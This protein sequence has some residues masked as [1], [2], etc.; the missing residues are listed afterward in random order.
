MANPT[1][2]L[3]RPWIDLSDFGLRVLHTKDAKNRH[4][5]MLMPLSWEEEPEQS[6]ARLNELQGRLSALVG[7][8]QAPVAGRLF[9]QDR[10]WALTGSGLSTFRGIW[11][12]LQ[13]GFPE[14]RLNQDTPIHYISLPRFLQHYAAQNAEKPSIKQDAPATSTT[15]TPKAVVELNDQEKKLAEFIAQ[16]TDV[17][18]RLAA[19]GMVTDARLH[20][21]LDQ[22]EEVI[23]EIKADE[24]NAFQGIL[25][26]Q[27]EDTLSVI[28]ANLEARGEG[29][30]ENMGP[31]DGVKLS[32]VIEAIQL[33]GQRVGS[34]NETRGNVQEKGTERTGLTE[35]ETIRSAFEKLADYELNSWRGLSV[36][37]EG[38]ETHYLACQR[39]SNP[40]TGEAPV[41]ELAALDQGGWEIPG[42]KRGPKWLYH[43]ALEADN[44]LRQI[45][46]F[47]AEPSM[48]EMW[49]QQGLPMPAFNDAGDAGDTGAAPVN[50][51][52]PTDM[53]TVATAGRKAQRVTNS[54]SKR[55]TFHLNEALRQVGLR[56][57]GAQENGGAD[58]E[59]LPALLEEQAQIQWKLF[60]IEAGQLMARIESDWDGMYKD[61]RDRASAL[62][63]NYPEL[64]EAMR[65]VSLE[66][67]LAAAHNL[68]VRHRTTAV[69]D[70][71]A[72]RLLTKDLLSLAEKT[73][74]NHERTV[75]FL[76]T[77][78]TRLNI[79]DDLDF[80][81]L[82]RAFAQLK[83]A[84]G[85]SV[86]TPEIEP[87]VRGKLEADIT[88][89][90][91]E[92]ENG[93]TDAT[94]SLTTGTDGSDRA[95]LQPGSGQPSLDGSRHAD[96]AGSKSAGE[97]DDR[98]GDQSSPAEDAG[99]AGGVR[100]SD[101]SGERSPG[102]S[103]ISGNTSDAGRQG[104]TEAADPDD[105]ASVLQGGSGSV[106]NGHAGGDAGR[107]SQASAGADRAPDSASQDPVSGAEGQT[108]QAGSGLRA[109]VRA[110]ADAGPGASGETATERQSDAGDSASLRSSDGSDGASDERSPGASGLGQ[111]P[112][113]D[114]FTYPEGHDLGGKTRA[115]R[116]EDNLAAMTLLF[117]LEKEEREPTNEERA[118]L[119]EYS[120]WGGID[121]NLFGYGNK[122]NFAIEAKAAI[123]KFRNQDKLS[124]KEYNSLQSTV[125]NAHYTHSGII[126]PMWR[127]IERLGV[128]VG[129]ILEP[130]CGL[131]NFKAY[132]PEPLATKSRFTGVEI[133]PITARIAQKVHPDS[134]VHPVGL[135]E[136]PIP[137]GFFDLAISNVPFGEYKVFDR[138]NPRW[139]HNIHNYFFLK[140]LQKLKPGGVTAFVTSTYTLDSDNAR[141]RE[142]IMDQAHVIGAFRLPMG[143]F[144]KNTQTEVMTDIIFLQKKGDFTPSYE[145]ADILKTANIEAPLL[146][147][148]E[149]YVDGETYSPGDMVPDRAINS[150]FVRHPQNILG[151]LGVVTSRFGF[152]LAVQG[153]SSIEGIQERLDKALQSGLPEGIAV[154]AASTS[155][156][157][158]SDD[159]AQR[160]AASRTGG[161]LDD[162][163]PGAIYFD[164]NLG[165]FR[166]IVVNSLGEMLASEQPVKV[167]KKQIQRMHGLLGLMEVSRKLLILQS[168]PENDSIN[169]EINALREQLN[170]DYDA[171]VQKFGAV[172]LGEN[173]R[174][175]R[176]DTRAPFMY[177][178]EDF[179]EKTGQAKKTAIFDQRVVSPTVKPPTSAESVQDALAISLAY[180]A[181][182]SL[183]YMSE[184]LSQ[185]DQVVTEEAVLAELIKQELAYTNP[186]TDKPET[187]DTYLSGNLAPKIEAA[188]A[189]AASDPAFKRNL[190]D[191]IAH[192]PAPLKP[193]QIKVGLDAFWLPKDV[194]E[195]FL[196]EALGLRIGGS[197]GVSANFD[198]VNRYW[199]IDSNSSK[200]LNSIARD[201]DHVAHSRWGTERCHVFRLLDN[202]F[203]NTVPVVRDK[204]QDN[205]PK[206][207]I[208]NPETLKAQGK[209]EEIIDAFNRWVYKSPARAKRLAGIYNERFNTWRLVEPDGSHMVYPG[210]SP[211]WE[212]RKHQNDFIWRAISGYN[213]L[214]AH[215]VGAG[216]TM[217][218]I[219]TAVRGK[220]LNRWKKPMDVVPNHMLR[221]FAADA[222]RIYPSSRILVLD[223]DDITPARRGEFV[224]RAAMGDWDLIVCTHST[225]SRI[226]IPASFEATMLEEEIER[227]RDALAVETE[228]NGRGTNHSQRD[229]EKKIKNLEAKLKKKTA[230]AAENRDNVLNLEEMGVDFIGIDEAHY[231]KNLGVDSARQIPG[232]S[233]SES[234]RA[235]DMFIK[236]RYLQDLHNGPYGVMMATGTPISNSVV[237]C[238]TFTRMMR[239]DLLEGAGILNFNDWMSLFGEIQ[240]K[241]EIKPE[242]GGYQVKSRLSRFKNLPEL[243]KMIRSFIDFKT[244]EDLNLPTPKIIP[245]A[246][247]APQSEFMAQFMKYIEARAR[248]VRG[249]KNGGSSVAQ[250]LAHLA[251]GALYGQNDKTRLDSMGRPDPDKFGEEL[252]DDILLTIATDGRKASLDPRLIHPS[253]PDDPNSKVNLCVKNCLEIY[254]RF[255]ADKAAQLIFCDFSSPTGKG[256][257]NVYDDIKKKLIAAGVPEAEIAFIHDAVT[258]DD[259]EALFEKVR[260]GEVR[261][262]LGSTSKMGVGTNVQ[263]RLVAMHQLD[264]PWKPA[265]IE[266]R[267]GRMDRQGNMF[268]EAYSF[269]YTTEDSFDLFMWETL[270]RKLAMIK[271]A[272]RHPDDCA[273]EMDEDV[274]MGYEDILAVTTGNPKIKEFIDARM[275]LDRLKRLESS[276]LDEQADLAEK[277]ENYQSRVSRFDSLLQTKREEQE[278]AL[279]H[280]PRHLLIE[281]AQPGNQDGDTCYIGGIKGLAEALK[282]QA[283]YVRAYTKRSIGHFGGFELVIDRMHDTPRLEM[284]RLDGNSDKVGRLEREPEFENLLNDQEKAVDPAVSTARALANHVHRIATDNGIQSTEESRKNLVDSIE[285]AKADIGKPF[286]YTAELDRVR[287]RYQELAEELGDVLAEGAEMD[288]TQIIGMMQTLVRETNAPVNREA[289]RVILGDAMDLADFP[290]TDDEEEAVTASMA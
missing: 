51:G 137:D 239:P 63:M 218:L 266:Q 182:I 59:L 185:Q 115:R 219:G 173:E 242:G 205:P 19:Q 38:K 176:R 206:Y 226:G 229:I 39:E 192:L 62:A 114:R 177:G 201:Q 183:P 254:E 144:S 118:I 280:Q 14:M 71:K 112:A 68:V 5:V 167:P 45:D 153:E 170:L 143:T 7:T 138:A 120:G 208:N 96:P 86:S 174:L 277:I 125:L 267:L 203:T 146:S 256:I 150:Y 64:T 85:T 246:V 108:E 166:T 184:L 92:P 187:R 111:S 233:S 175:Y 133:D 50:D 275:Q 89:P 107:S 147:T 57:N 164:D 145:P 44:T 24:V 285:A 198:E 140:S 159:I 180:T 58:A 128:P 32:L 240:H 243:V 105:A 212:P 250:D 8:P 247:V 288:P 136:A 273:R 186:E 54:E 238:Y 237:E 178:L 130:S 222:Q 158:K 251:R 181:G 264:P 278:L 88:A 33:R 31:L 20:S 29:S 56:I 202:A 36:T 10:V 97:S 3:T 168:E 6:T 244:R 261:F 259:K 2:T 220:Q 196:E 100:G 9:Y 77:V 132:Q 270:N 121:P 21:R 104:D 78:A 15:G 12:T 210:M 91:G 193:S 245:K 11:T 282:K 188:K 18:D 197:Y 84:D 142:E 269:I 157:I 75:L 163:V 87:D 241:M 154:P 253:L 284:V 98:T 109:E 268:E 23:E 260:S 13:K 262:L 103:T 235:W 217:Q 30:P 211:A 26:V 37:H 135:E 52:Q 223:K 17:M 148:T 289:L 102:A 195:D 41:L 216:K 169:A 117:S 119:A 290:D 72:M 141:V 28:K 190:D 200:S 191:L 47:E 53:Q 81:P 276:H 122:P 194:V 248:T 27:S 73:P 165:D 67:N 236:C 129:R 134:T 263:E 69:D 80:A 179:D 61:E 228:K 274:S 126:G 106:G 82:D 156:D 65:L 22:L 46:H 255:T 113:L 230:A 286:E 74:L 215:V 93:Q 199:R 258:D 16:R 207:E 231:Y 152:D 90:Q 149:K 224:A 171:F 160:Q 25:D 110:D 234:V 162:L 60:D 281:G 116:C 99:I 83:T 225:F 76:D 189:A 124:Y 70:T 1:P 79:G 172:S 287:Q 279:K 94:E 66:P 101:R 151:D 123:E 43:Y 232:V 204:V 214:T 34:G 227:L 35:G 131:M 139:G 272:M 127:A 265:D 155:K 221:Q 271:Q 95:V 48:V 55:L 249:G 257:F 42:I 209:Y 283:G 4:M 161:K 40:R 213:S 252:P 49:A